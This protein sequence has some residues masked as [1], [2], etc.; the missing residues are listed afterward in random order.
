MHFHFVGDGILCMCYIQRNK[1]Y[2]GTKNLHAWF[3]TQ[4][5]SYLFVMESV[6]KHRNVLKFMNYFVV[7]RFSAMLIKTHQRKCL[8]HKGE[9][10][11][12]YSN[13]FGLYHIDV[14]LLVNVYATPCVNYVKI[15]FNTVKFVFSSSTLDFG[16]EH[17]KTQIFQKSIQGQRLYQRRISKE[18]SF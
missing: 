13:F 14:R 18:W 1:T 11:L 5:L 12:S 6:I 8:W 17:L 7:C 9:N 4:L 15:V 16:E 3:R 10:I 2:I